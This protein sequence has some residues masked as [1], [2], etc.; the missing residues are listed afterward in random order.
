[1]DEE[2]E[3]DYLRKKLMR[4]ELASRTDIRYMQIALNLTGEPETYKDNA[5]RLINKIGILKA[6]KESANG[7]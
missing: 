7:I 5:L 6:L 2:R 3:I 1:M 4:L